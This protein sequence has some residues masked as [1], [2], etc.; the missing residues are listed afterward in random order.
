MVDTEIQARR[1]VERDHR[2]PSN[3]LTSTS[4]MIQE[5]SAGRSASQRCRF[6]FSLLWRSVSCF[7]ASSTTRQARLTLC[8]S[9][10][11]LLS[12][13]DLIRKP[14][15]SRFGTIIT[16]FRRSRCHRVIH[17]KL[18]RSSF[19]VF[20]FTD[21]KHQFSPQICLNNPTFIFSLICI[22]DSKASRPKDTKT[23]TLTL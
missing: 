2:E 8:R 9:L 10:L 6:C 16:Q 4:K 22:I 15:L 7:A 13:A 12:S 5:G 11:A 14:Q 21:F 19:W 18:R 3:Q 23:T 1:R 17:V 20:F